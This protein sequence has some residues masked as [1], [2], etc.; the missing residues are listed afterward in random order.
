[1]NRREIERLSD[2]LLKW[3]VIDVPELTG[4][5]RDAIG[6]LRHV[7]EEHLDQS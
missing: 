3:T 1:M 2:L 4:A 5:D 7:L 6:Q